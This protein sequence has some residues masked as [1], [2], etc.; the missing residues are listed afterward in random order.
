MAT[1]T[2]GGVVRF[3]STFTNTGQVPYN[4]ITIMPN[5]RAVLA[6]ATPDGDQTATSGT[7]TVTPTSVSWTG[8]IPVGGTVVISGS[9]TVHNTV[10]LNTVLTSTTSTSAAGSNCPSGGT[11]PRCSVSV[12]VLT[13]GLTITK[14]ATATA[15]VPGQPVGYTI[16]VTDSGQTPYTGAVVTDS[17]AGVVGDAAYNGDAAATA[18]TVTYASPVLSWTGNL[19]PGASATITYSVT[20]DNP[21]TGGKVMTNTVV[22]AAVGST[23]PAGGGNA[24]CTATVVVL[25]PGLT[26]VKTASVATATPGGT[27][28]YTITV[29]DSG[30][31]P[32]TGATVTDPLAGVLADAAYNA[33]AA[34]TAGTVTYASPVLSWTGNL[35]PG[36]SAT[37]TYSVTVNNP[38]TRGGILVNTVTSATAGSNCASGSTDPRCSVTVAVSQLLIVEPGGCGHH[39]AGR[40]DPFHLYLHQ[41]RAGPLRRDHDRADRQRLVRLRHFGRRPDRDLRDAD[42]HRHR[43]VLDRG[44]PGRRDGHH[45][46]HLHG[47]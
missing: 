10:P 15:V 25:T 2:P 28:G 17:L 21:D 43:R 24:A 45:H 18:G 16:T 19:V 40:G 4:G 9:V 12:T 14:T 35:A 30:Q 26:I 13:P 41:Y 23:C 33:D 22:S 1:T 47:G 3:T 42:H 31:T 39:D 27:V 46:R 5:A 37:I 38:D 34:A 6:Y 36:A 29:T 11:D 8:N 7:L 44:Y 32:Y 20:V